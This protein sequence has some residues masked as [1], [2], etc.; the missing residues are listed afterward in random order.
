MESET[1]LPNN[2]RGL[3]RC[4]VVDHDASPIYER[5]ALCSLHR[6]SKTEV[7]N[8]LNK[9]HQAPHTLTTSTTEAC[10]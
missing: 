4:S 10:F 7:D 8:G 5:D 9:D 2:T 6:S 1:Q 3:S